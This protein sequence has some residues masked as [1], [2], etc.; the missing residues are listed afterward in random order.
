LAGI[1]EVPVSQRGRVFIA[2]PPPQH[3][4]VSVGHALSGRQ[5]T[6][7]PPPLL[8]SDVGEAVRWP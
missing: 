3:M 4:K 8:Q 5:H 1:A 6:V 7:V 2:A